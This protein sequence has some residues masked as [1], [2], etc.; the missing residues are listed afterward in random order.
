MLTPTVAA[1]AMLLWLAPERGGLR[2]VLALDRA[3]WRALPL[4]VAAP[5][6][7]HLGVIALLGL[8]GLAAFARPPGGLP[9]LAI[10]LGANLVLGTLLALGEEVGW[11]GYLLPRMPGGHPIRAMLLVGLMHGCWHLPLLL[12][13]VL[14]H[15]GADPWRVVPLFLATLTL[16]GLFYGYLR[17]VSGSVWP[18]AVAHGVAN[19]GWQIFDRF[20]TTRTPLVRE[21]LGGKSGALILAGLLALG[22]VLVRRMRRPGFIWRLAV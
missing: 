9:D 1:L 8:S 14:Y 6:G 18:V 2:H 13:T 4:A 22:L 11:R 16:A 20:D 12:S 15:P 3:G 17:A 7:L 10:D 21:Y 19:V 5:L